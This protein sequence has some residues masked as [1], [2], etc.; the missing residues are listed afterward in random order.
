MKG[1]RPFAKT[2][3]LKSG[4]LFAPVSFWLPRLIYFWN[5]YMQVIREYDETLAYPAP[6][7][8]KDTFSRIR[9]AFPVR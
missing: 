1:L 3:F 4:K 2:G 5:R 9:A 6:Y 7:L 8:E